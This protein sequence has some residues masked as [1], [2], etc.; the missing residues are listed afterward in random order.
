MICGVLDFTLTQPQATLG[1]GCLAVVAAAIAYRGVL[2]NIEEQ[3]RSER[4]KRRAD[5]VLEAASEMYMAGN[6]LVT[7]DFQNPTERVA[8]SHQAY[9]SLAKLELL[10][11]EDAADKAR[12]TLSLLDK[13][14][15]DGRTEDDE[16]TAQ[17]GD[18]LH[19][20]VKSL[21]DAMNWA[22]LGYQP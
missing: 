6:R 8:L 1:A 20:A 14:V 5:L 4:R 13:G 7:G 12:D 22:E 16:W 2:R 3:R 10:G 18:S 9:A 21:Q 19:A 15:A 11:F 17:V